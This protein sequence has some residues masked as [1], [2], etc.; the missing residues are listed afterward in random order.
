VFLL[1]N[2]VSKAGRD[3]KVLNNKVIGNNHANFGN[4]N[5]I[6]GQVPSGGGI[7]VMAADNVEVANNEIRDN[8]SYGV[9]VTSLEIS[10]P[11]GTQ[12]DVG[13]TPENVWVHTNTYANNGSKP[14][15]Q[16]LKNGLQGRDLLWDL[17]GYSNRW[18]EPNATRMVPLPS[19][20]FPLFV[21]RGY[22]RML[23][24]YAKYWG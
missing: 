5:A 3:H 9:A 7:L 11:K 22:W 13:P 19:S 23:N 17:S 21:R 4:P 16:I 1:P 2:N 14:D 12:F 15:P 24:W 10:Y 8:N 6:V 18:D 20:P